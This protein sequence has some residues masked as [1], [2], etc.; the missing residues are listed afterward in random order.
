MIDSRRTTIESPKSAHAH[1]RNSVKSLFNGELWLLA[2]GQTARG[3]NRG[4][5][6]GWCSK[7]GFL[8]IEIGCIKFKIVCKFSSVLSVQK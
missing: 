3:G 4:N 7:T 8:S 1:A 5:S 2:I 6:R